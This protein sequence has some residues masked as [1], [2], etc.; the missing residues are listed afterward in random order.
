MCFPKTQLMSLSFWRNILLSLTSPMS[1]R[2]LDSWWVF[3]MLSISTTPRRWN[4]PLKLCKN[5]WTLVGVAVHRMFMGFA[6]SSC[7]KSRFFLFLIFLRSFRLFCDFCYFLECTFKVSH[8]LT[9]TMHVY[10]YHEN[11]C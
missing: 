9:L 6:T 11:K 8:V 5:L 1:P 10:T 3:F 2:H 7:A 4:T